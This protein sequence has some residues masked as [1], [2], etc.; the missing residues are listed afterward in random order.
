MLMASVRELWGCALD[1]AE[2][3]G[4]ALMRGEGDGGMAAGVE[5][6]ASEQAWGAGRGL[7]RGACHL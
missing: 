1:R 6:Q 5:L 4:K 7:L 2:S 3:V